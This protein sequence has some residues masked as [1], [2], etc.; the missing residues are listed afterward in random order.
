MARAGRRRDGTLGAVSTWGPD[1]EAQA[2]VVGTAS[3]RLLAAGVGRDDRLGALGL[4]GVLSSSADGDGVVHRG[5]RDL[6]AEFELADADADRWLQALVGI[7]IVRQR[8]DELV[9]A[10]VEPPASGG[11]RL[12]DFLANA[13][14]AADPVALARRRSPARVLQGLAAAAAVVVL[15]A[16]PLLGRGPTQSGS[17]RATGDST[18][19][20]SDDAGDVGAGRSVPSPWRWGDWGSGAG[21]RSVR[22][23]GTAPP[24]TTS[25][26]VLEECPVGEPLLEVIGIA[27]G[28]AT[29][30]PSVEGLIR[31]PT[32]VEVH[33]DGFTV[34]V[35][36]GDHVV[37][38]GW[39]DDP[40]TV[41][42]GR[43]LRW[44]LHL[45]VPR[46]PEVT[47]TVVLDQWRWAD[48]TAQ[49]ACR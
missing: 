23:N 9:L 32:S 24:P 42:P 37:E 34:V 3:A 29:G 13:E 31:N 47:A 1:E 12:A 36:A 39:P 15:V 30:V 21:D 17:V 28:S 16:V 25:T 22:A 48:G 43:S 14:V 5:F 27:D 40:L 38:V 26:T 7:G 8:S 10:G 45:P 20:A 44:A 18:T 4:L 2:D 41:A 35:T 19:T 11:L 33:V 6:C 46:V 49:Q